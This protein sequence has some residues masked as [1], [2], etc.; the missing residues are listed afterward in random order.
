MLLGEE[1]VKVPEFGVEGGVGGANMSAIP[2][3]RLP[4]DFSFRGD[5]S[6]KDAADDRYSTSAIATKKRANY[7]RI[8]REENDRL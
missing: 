3:K 4:N 2:D 6:A 7:V 5:V 8:I 1:N